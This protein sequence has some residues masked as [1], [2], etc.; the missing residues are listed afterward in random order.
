[1][2]YQSRA[3]GGRS[4]DGAL[5]GT[6]GL[7]DPVRWV[8]VD[9]SVAVLDLT[10]RH[11]GGFG[12]RGSFSFAVNRLLPRGV[13]VAAGI[14]NTLVWGGSDTEQSLYAV[15]SRSFRLRANALEPLSR[16]IVTLGAGNGRFVPL[17]HE[18]TRVGVFGGVAM[19]VVPSAGTFAEW[20]GESLNLGVSLVP[21]VDLPLVVTGAWADATEEVG[22][23]RFNL[24]VGWNFSRA[25]R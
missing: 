16:A 11:G 21:L 25:P 23:G 17:D 7:G 20:T 6:V 2:G 4:P 1:V 14:Q 19:Q 24:A 15:A 8:G 5:G 10:P 3:R 18:H 12:E 13:A 22:R 9:V